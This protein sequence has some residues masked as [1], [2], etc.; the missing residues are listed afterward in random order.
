MF[1]HCLF[2]IVL[3]GTLAVFWLKID[4]KVYNNRT[5]LELNTVFLKFFKLRAHLMNNFNFELLN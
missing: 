1:M 3:K 5:Q 2:S 4:I